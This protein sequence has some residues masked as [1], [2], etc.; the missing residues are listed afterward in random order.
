MQLQK[1]DI[2]NFK[3]IEEASLEFSGGA[4]CLVGSNGM[5]KSNLLE[6]IWYLAMGRSPRLLTDAELVRHGERQMMLRGI[7]S[8]G[9]GATDS[10]GASDAAPSLEVALG[11][12]EGRRKR[13]RR[14]G[15]ECRR[16]S[17][18]IGTV[19]VVLSQP[20][21]LQLV[22]G[23]AEE[24]RHLM[25]NVISQADASYL[26]HLIRYSEALKQRN[27]MLRQ[28]ISDPVLLEAVESQMET[29]AAEVTATR[30]RWCDDMAAPFAT[31]YSLIAP[32]TETAGMS[33][34]PSVK[35]SSLSEALE[36]TR[37]RDAAL[38]YTTVGPH[39]DDLLLTLSGHDVRRIGSQG[40]MKSFT[41]ALRLA[42]FRY[43][44]ARAASTPILLLD[45][46]FDKL[47]ASRVERIV[48]TVTSPDQDFG[49]IF[50]TDTNRKHIDSILSRTAGDYRLFGVEEGRFSILPPA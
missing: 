32:D 20:S 10:S 22:T 9:Q 14:D 18:H 41:V 48:A 19:P 50:I 35:E 7:F 1:I 45:D 3:N 42:V 24:R 17:D 38:G 16:L 33:Y 29:A 12:E 49:Q 44:A 25:D 21:D 6:A 15:K 23:S 11:W 37:T 28:G 34:G 27:S 46:I 31:Y 8:R 4:N 40:Q 5:G 39:R 47:D 2:L 26:R 30:K 43:L 36:R 13:L